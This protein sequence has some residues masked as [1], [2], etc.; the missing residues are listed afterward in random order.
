MSASPGELFRL[1]QSADWSNGVLGMPFL[2]KHSVG[3]ALGDYSE[4]LFG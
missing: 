2:G 1:G 3:L 4:T